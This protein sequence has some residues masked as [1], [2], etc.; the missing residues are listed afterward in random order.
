MHPGNEHDSKTFPELYE[1]LKKYAIKTMVMDAGY[2]NPAIAKLLIDEEITPLFPYKRPMTKKGFL[3]SSK[4]K[5]TKS[6]GSMSMFM[7]NTMTVTF[8]LGIRY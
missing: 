2:K 3:P 4:R 5:G 8:A 1:K 6:S 7:T